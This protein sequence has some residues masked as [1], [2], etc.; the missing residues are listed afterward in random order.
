MKLSYEPGRLLLIAA[1]IVLLPAA[2]NAQDNTLEVNR[3]T[4]DNVIQAN[5][6]TAY[7]TT[8]SNTVDDRDNDDDEFPWGLLGLAGLAGLLGLK[9]RDDARDIHVDARRDSTR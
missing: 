5:D 7:E 9:R 1:G 2:A 8:M 4:V 6:A 3:V